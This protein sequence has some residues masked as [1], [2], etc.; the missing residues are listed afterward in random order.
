M[1]MIIKMVGLAAAVL[2]LVGCVS[3]GSMTKNIVNKNDKS[4][5]IYGIAIQG[6]K[7]EKV[8]VCQALDVIDKRCN[9]S[10]EILFSV[11]SRFGF[12]SAAGGTFA[13]S[14]GNLGIEPF[15]CG[16]GFS[17]QKHCNYV[18]VTVEPGKLGTVLEVVSRPGDNVCEWNGMPRAG[19]VVCESLGWSYKDHADLI[20]SFR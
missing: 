1:K 16:T 20:T 2:S 13:F 19:G 11:M 17:D 9:D 6:T 12:A 18:K 10:N 15:V 7:E 4:G 8:E 3:V 14:S 5:E